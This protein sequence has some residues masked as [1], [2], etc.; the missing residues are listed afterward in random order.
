MS[1]NSTYS[2]I[3]RK[4]DI[5]TLLWQ[6]VLQ[7][8]SYYAVGRYN[9]SHCYCLI[10]ENAICVPGWPPTAGILHPFSILSCLVS[11]GSTVYICTIIV[12]VRRNTGVW[13][14]RHPSPHHRNFD[15]HIQ[16][17]SALWRAF[18]RPKRVES[19]QRCHGAECRANFKQGRENRIT[20]RQDRCHG[21]T[22]NRFQERGSDCTKTDVVEK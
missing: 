6:I 11:R 15:A 12:I 18:T 14:A 22:S 3:S 9:T 17:R 2:T 4:A 21:G 16:H 7:G 13:P 19:S 5:R 1:G 10:Q 8:G 20:C